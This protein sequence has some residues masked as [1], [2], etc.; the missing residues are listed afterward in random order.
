M[1]TAETMFAFP[2]LRH[3]NLNKVLA[4]LTLTVLD[5]RDVLEASALT[6]QW[7][8]TLQTSSKTSLLLAPSLLTAGQMRDA[9]KVTALSPN[10]PPSK[11][12]VSSVEKQLAHPVRNA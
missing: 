11:V 2:T 9:N 5:P 7:L 3:S 10:L 4:N 8:P 6:P 1:N 12:P